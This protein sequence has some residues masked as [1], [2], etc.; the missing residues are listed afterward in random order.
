MVVFLLQKNATFVEI[1]PWK[2]P[3]GGSVLSWSIGRRVKEK[4][5]AKVKAKADPLRGRQ[6]RKA[7]AITGI[8]R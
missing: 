6:T 5:E 3:L 4:A 1:F 8:L 7:R 2:I